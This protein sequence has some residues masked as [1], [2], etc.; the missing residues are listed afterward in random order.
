MKILLDL[1]G[2][3]NVPCGEVLV[4]DHDALW[5]INKNV[6]D[7]IQ[8]TKAEIIWMSAWQ[9]EANYLNEFL[10][11]KD[12]KTTDSILQKD[13]INNFESDPIS[14]K[15]KAIDHIV[16]KYED[17]IVVSIDDEFDLERILENHVHIKTDSDIGLC[18]HH[19]DYLN[20]LY[21][22]EKSQTLT[23]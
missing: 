23:Y 1:D 5:T 20:K 6:L 2:V 10:G 21:E 17:H 8:T 16:N 22:H 4:R 7:W 12:F 14:R 19:F 9:D 11:I 18:T 15:I 13:K 3:L